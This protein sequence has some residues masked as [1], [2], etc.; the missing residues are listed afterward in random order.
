M[1]AIDLLTWRRER[2][3]KQDALA[4]MLGV[5]RKTVVNWETGKHRLPMDLAKRLERLAY[6]MAPKA[7][8]GRPELLTSSAAHLRPDLKLYG[9]SHKGGQSRG[10]EH[11]ESLGFKRADE[12]SPLPFAILESAEYI[13]ALARQRR[14]V[15][16]DAEIRKQNLAAGEA[17]AKQARIE[18]GYPRED[19][20]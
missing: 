15:A 8:E 4:A 6:T 9:I 3:L 13:E 19:D 16:I 1:D 14:Q 20:L 10:P 12:H 17:R 2:K 5:T 7:I 18:L 11:P